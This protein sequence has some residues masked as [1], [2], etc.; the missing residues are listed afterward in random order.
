MSHPELSLFRLTY[1]KQVNVAEW[2]P[3]GSKIAYLDTLTAGVGTLHVVDAASANDLLIA[4]GV[5]DDPMP[6]WAANG[7]QFVYSTGTQTFVVTMA[8]SMKIAP[9]SL[10]GHVS[11][12]AWFA[13]TAHSLI[14]ALSD[15]Q[16]GVYLVDT[17]NQHIQQL[18]RQDMISGPILWTEVP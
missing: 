3:D 10:R 18:S 9:L 14:V 11:A 1:G 5:A 16:S 12:L 7:Q 8:G 6:V 15:G 17:Q 2:S 13:N 4:K